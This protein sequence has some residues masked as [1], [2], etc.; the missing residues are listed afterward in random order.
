MQAS[1]GLRHAMPR[2]IIIHRI[3]MP[4][5]M[6]APGCIPGI[7]RPPAPPIGIGG[8]AAGAEES[9]SVA[10]AR[11]CWAK[12]AGIIAVPAASAAIRNVRFTGDLHRTGISPKIGGCAEGIPAGGGMVGAGDADVVDFQVTAAEDRTWK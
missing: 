2:C 12:A 3:I 9:G 11:G 10:G 5:G 6:P 1:F 8:F 7:A 4:A